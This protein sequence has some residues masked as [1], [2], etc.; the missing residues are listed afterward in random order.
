M[1]DFYE[2]DCRLALAI[3]LIRFSAPVVI[4]RMDNAPIQVKVLAV[5]IRWA[6]GT[7]R[8]PRSDYP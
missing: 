7:Q 2:T 4:D 1:S 5:P 6:Y 8:K 3:R